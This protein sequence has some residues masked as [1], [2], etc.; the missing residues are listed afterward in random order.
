MKKIYLNFG[1]GGADS[2]AV[3]CD[4]KTLEKNLNR[5]IGLKVEKALEKMG[6]SVFSYQQDKN[7]IQ[8]YKEENK[9]AYD[10]AVSIHCNSS[11]IPTAQGVE[12]LYYPTSTRGQALAQA[13]QKSITANIKVRDRGI[14]ERGDLCFLRK[15]K[16]PAAL[17]EIGFISNPAE[18]QAL[19]KAHRQ[20]SL[21]DC[22]AAGIADFFNSQA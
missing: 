14:K 5:V 12:T 20:K 1:H 21:A 4:G 7:V 16:A 3:G 13:I 10:C 6:F 17:V 15:T 22:I 9:G 8:T 2:G 11:A 19:K 18:L